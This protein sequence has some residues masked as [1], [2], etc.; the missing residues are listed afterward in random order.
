MPKIIRQLKWE[1][2]RVRRGSDVRK[3]LQI[4]KASKTET[5]SVHYRD[6]VWN[7]FSYGRTELDHRGRRGGTS[8]SQLLDHTP[9]QRVRNGGVDKGGVSPEIYFPCRT[10]YATGSGSSCFKEDEIGFVRV[11][12]VYINIYFPCLHGRTLKTTTEWQAFY[13]L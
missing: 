3:L 4:R 6:G 9:N 10:I 1:I 2:R 8:P 5:K 13:P 7:S 11:C 12:I